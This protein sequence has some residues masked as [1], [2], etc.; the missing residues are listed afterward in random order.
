M[1]VYKHKKETSYVELPIANY[2]MNRVT[3]KAFQ[4]CHK[5]IEEIHRS[6]FPICY[7]L[8]NFYNRLYWKIKALCV[9]K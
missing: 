7:F 6:Y 9:H 2:D 5:E 4:E 3:A 8:K 1:W